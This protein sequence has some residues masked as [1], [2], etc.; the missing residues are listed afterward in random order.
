MKS[1]DPVEL[2]RRWISAVNARDAQTVLSLYNEDA[3][4]LPTF[5]PEVR[6]GI[7]AIERYFDQ[8]YMNDKVTVELVEDTITVQNLGDG[9]AVIGGLY[10]WEFVSA[11]GVR[12][13]KGRYTYVV[14]MKNPRPI[15]HHHSS[16]VPS[17]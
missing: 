14:D 13:P 9:L 16:V 2:L 12:Q 4:L 17:G 6:H 7:K 1:T 10:N 15:V 11:S 3:L 8:V 5:S